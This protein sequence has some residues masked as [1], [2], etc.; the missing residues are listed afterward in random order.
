MDFCAISFVVDKE[1]SNDEYTPCLL[2]SMEMIVIPNCS[3]CVCFLTIY[4][5]FGKF[6]LEDKKL[7]Q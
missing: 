6:I 1:S 3:L 4:E 7:K 2:P 5:R